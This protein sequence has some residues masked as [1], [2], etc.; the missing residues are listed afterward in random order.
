M[1]EAR[2]EP[3]EA[4][5]ALASALEIAASADEIE[6][7]LP[8]VTRSLRTALG[9][10]PLAELGETEPAFGLQFAPTYAKEGDADGSS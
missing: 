4:L 1:A 2:L 8:I 9:A 6:R 10:D 7:A 5:A 3:T